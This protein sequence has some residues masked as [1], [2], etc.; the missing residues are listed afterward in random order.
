MTLRGQPTY[1]ERSGS[2]PQDLSVSVSHEDYILLF[3]GFSR[4]NIT[5]ISQPSTLIKQQTAKAVE[6][7]LSVPQT[8]RHTKFLLTVYMKEIMWKKSCCFCVIRVKTWG[9][10]HDTLSP[11]QWLT[12][13]KIRYQDDLIACC[14]QKGRSHYS[15]VCDPW[16]PPYLLLPET[17]PTLPLCWH[18][19][20][21]S[22]KQFS[23][24]KLEKMVYLS[25]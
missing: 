1:I 4:V 19:P 17:H 25:F 18:L 14:S 20:N 9:F 5:L 7:S 15:L 21:P 3:V 6:K 11:R 10:C 22:Q 16:L 12:T 23:S 24:L 8:H 13:R 2:F